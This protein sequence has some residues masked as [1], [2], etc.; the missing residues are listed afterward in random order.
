MSESRL[1]DFY[2]SID[3]IM[4]IDQFYNTFTSS[5]YPDCIQVPKDLWPYE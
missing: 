3:Q 4:S 1:K 2:R 5:D